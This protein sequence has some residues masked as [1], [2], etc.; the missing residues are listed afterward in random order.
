MSKKARKKIV[1]LFGAGATQG[2]VS[3]RNNAVR[4]TMDDIREGI[5]KKASGDNKINKVCPR[6]IN[7][8]SIQQLDIEH[9]IT[10]YEASSSNN[11]TKIAK[12]LKESFKTEIQEKLALLGKD[13]EPILYPALLD[14][15]NIDGLNEDI[16]GIITINY[17]D[18]LD[19]SVN[20]ILNG[21]SYFIKISGNKKYLKIDEKAEYPILKLHGSFNWQK[22]YPIALVNKG[23]SKNGENVIWAPPGVFKKTEK[24]PF[25]I[26][27]GR[28]MEI[29]DCDV[30]R[31]IGCSLNRNDWQLIS[32]IYSTQMLNKNETSYDIELIDKP[33]ACDSIADKYTYLKFRKIYEISE[34]K[35]YINGEIGGKNGDISIS[36]I[37]EALNTPDRNIFDTWLKSKGEYLIANS[38]KLDT[39]RGFFNNYIRERG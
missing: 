28:A 36:T 21:I 4:I 26:L 15:H 18:L 12:Y 3:L 39:P 8:L 5:R 17:E 27:W 11:H 22:S 30:L 25:S 31:I 2:E 7:E 1:Y 23:K 38:I 16:N 24:Y 10:L 35:S 6:L 13:F 9:L 20:K 29:L 34:V 33:S 14:M 32:L 37:I 19:R